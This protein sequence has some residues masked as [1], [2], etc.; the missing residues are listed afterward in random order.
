ML[1][2]SDSPDWPGGCGPWI[3]LLHPTASAHQTASLLPI[4][5]ALAFLLLAPGCNEVGL[6]RH[7]AQYGLWSYCHPAGHGCGCLF[8]SLS[9]FLIIT[10]SSTTAF[11]V[12]A[13]QGLWNLCVTL[14]WC[15]PSMCLSSASQWLH[16][17]RDSL[18]PIVHVLMG[19]VYLLLPPV[20][21]PIIYGA[22]TKQIRTSGASYV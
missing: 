16:R 8:I 6:Y 18:H 7:I 2:N 10:N 20:I 12:G 14:V 9:Y 1:N 15:W 19:D 22:K 4:Q 17:F 11:Q 5:C 21:N 3:P 13:G